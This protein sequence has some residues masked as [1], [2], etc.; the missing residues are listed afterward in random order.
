MLELHERFDAGLRRVHL[1][2][3]HPIQVEVHAQAA[4]AVALRGGDDEPSVPA[5][6]VV[7]H[8]VRPDVR[9]PEHAFDDVLWRPDVGRQLLR[10][11]APLRPQEQ[12]RAN[13]ER[14]PGRR[15]RQHHPPSHHRVVPRVV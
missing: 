2:F 14:Q 13:D 10:R 15:G 1:R 9:E 11:R 6:Q 4:R 12:P 5:P 8:V 7:H 3:L